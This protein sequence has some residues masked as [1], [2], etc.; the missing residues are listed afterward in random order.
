MCGRLDNIKFY[1]AY[2]VYVQAGYCKRKPSRHIHQE[3]MLQIDDLGWEAYDDLSDLR[4]IIAH[5][6]IDQAP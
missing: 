5:M 2:N 6:I 3:W 1:S 4:N